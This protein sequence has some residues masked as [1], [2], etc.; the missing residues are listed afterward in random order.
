MTMGVVRFVTLLVGVS[1]AISDL[2]TAFI[3]T[4]NSPLSRVQESTPIFTFNTG[5]STKRETEASATSTGLKAWYDENGDRADADVDVDPTV[6]VANKFKMVTCM[7][8][9]CAQKRIENG[10]DEYSTFGA[11]F[12]RSRARSPWVV[13]IEEVACL[14][15]CKKGPCA[16]VVHED[17]EGTVVLKGMDEAEST[18]K[19]FH[20]IVTEDDADRVWSCVEN[21]IM[22]M[23]E[24]ESE[25]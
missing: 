1:L 16:G 20:R 14:G 8:D 3:P 24:E 19:V 13:C 18:A 9:A 10:Q 17:Y 2:T 15:S 4:R 6:A 25:E 5:T 21:A 12:S 7:S 11:F 23:A 22:G